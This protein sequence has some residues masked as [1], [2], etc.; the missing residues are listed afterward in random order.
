MIG[1]VM[2]GTNDVAR[3]RAFYDPILGLLGAAPIPAYTS[4]TRVFYTSGAG[5]PMLSITKPHDGAPATAGNGTMVALPAPSA[6]VVDAV[7]AKALALGAADEGA[8]GLRG[9]AFYGAYF[10]DPDGNKLAVFH[11]KR[12]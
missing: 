12:G 2:L 6:E 4:E 10:R 7:H 11:V 1:Y 5:A 3:S 9:A 8:P